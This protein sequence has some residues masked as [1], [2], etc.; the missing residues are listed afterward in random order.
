MYRASCIFIQ[1]ISYQRLHEKEDHSNVVEPSHY[2][3]VKCWRSQPPFHNYE[4]LQ[5]NKDHSHFLA[6]FTRRQPHSIVSRLHREK[7]R[8]RLPSH[9]SAAPKPTQECPAQQISRHCLLGCGK[10]IPHLLRLEHLF[11]LVILYAFSSIVKRRPGRDSGFP[12]GDMRI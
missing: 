5:G 6:H 7:P 1:T 10:L 8:S 3:N 11:G 12:D 9:R 4:H 2:Q